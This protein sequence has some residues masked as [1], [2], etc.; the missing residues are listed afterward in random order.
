M[1][2]EAFLC[3]AVPSRQ[4]VPSTL[5]SPASLRIPYGTVATIHIPTLHY[6]W[7][8]KFSGSKKIINLATISIWPKDK[9]GVRSRGVR[10]NGGCGPN[11]CPVVQMRFGFGVYKCDLEC[12]VSQGSYECTRTNVLTL[13]VL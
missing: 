8:E 5:S 10:T 7:A 3:A 13:T 9:W 6:T 4:R 12:A 2:L 1:W 11:P